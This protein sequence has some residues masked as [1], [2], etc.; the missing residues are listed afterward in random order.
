[1]NIAM[2]KTSDSAHYSTFIEGR[3]RNYF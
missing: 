2:F 3:E 1:M